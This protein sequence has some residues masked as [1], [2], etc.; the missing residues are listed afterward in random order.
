MLLV[1]KNQNI[2]FVKKEAMLQTVHGFGG[3]VPK[4][5]GRVRSGGR[6][7]VDIPAAIRVIPADTSC[8]RAFTQPS[9]GPALWRPSHYLYPPKLERETGF[10]PATFIFHPRVRLRST[11][12]TAENAVLPAEL[13]PLPKTLVEGPGLEPETFRFGVCCAANC[14]TPR[15]R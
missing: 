11:L 7:L 12:R 9:G 8:R 2:W 6:E 5:I 4:K 1:D 15:S 13:L 3:I 10:E 14:A